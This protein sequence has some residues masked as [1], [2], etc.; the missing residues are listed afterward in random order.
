LAERRQIET[1]PSEAPTVSPDSSALRIRLDVTEGP[2]RGQAFTFAGHDTFLVGRSPR[3][4]FRLPAKDEYFSRLH[5]MV[6]V[7][8]PQCRLTDMGSKNGTYVNG[9][10]TASADLKDGDV[11]KAGTTVL[12][13]AIEA[14]AGAPVPAAASAVT[15]TALP[16]PPA[17]APVA[18]SGVCPIC[19]APFP[20]GGTRPSPPLCRAC[21]AQARSQPQPIQGYRIV[22]ELGRGGMGVVSLALRTADG[23]VVALKTITPAAA[24]VR[25]HVERFLREADILRRLAHPTIVA[26]RETGESSGQLYFAMDYVRGTDA[27]RL[28]HEEGPLPV[29]R[30]VGLVCPLLEGLGYAHAH[31]FVHRDVKPANVLVETVGGKDVVRLADF[32]LARVY[33]ASPLSG[34]TM[35]G[36]LGGTV[37]FMAPEQITQFREAQPPVDQYA[38][39]ATL[40]TLL[41]GRNVYDLPSQFTDQVLLLLQEDPVPIRTR[42]PDLPGELAGVIHRALAREPA[43][44]FA[45][46]GALRRALLPFC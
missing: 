44:R 43:S 8:P 7:N 28:L 22:R 3:A 12:R 27:A 38:A 29:G 37:A 2:H 11:I 5:F 23:T 15:R 4:H 17:A 46:V 40:Y 33:Q 1:P 34:L 30:A 24:G 39:A 42:R 25:A 26:L 18:A 35:R 31:G 10:K 16:L 41:T 32:G 36:E 9:R 6:E 14:G 45:D 13:V 20:R 19:A 21:E